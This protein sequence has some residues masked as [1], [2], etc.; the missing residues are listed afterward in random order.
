MAKGKKRKQPEAQVR[1]LFAV[2]L[3]GRAC[4]RLAAW[5]AARGGALCCA[6]SHGLSYACVRACVN[7]CVVSRS[8]SL[9]VCEPCHACV[10][11]R[12]RERKSE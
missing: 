1:P 8:L 3:W 5:Y 9:Y 10:C 12:E 6:P 2:F 7:V 4:R 11:E